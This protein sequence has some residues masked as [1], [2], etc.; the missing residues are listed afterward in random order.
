MDSGDIAFD[1]NRTDHIASGGYPKNATP[2][3]GAGIDRLLHRDRIQGNT[4]SNRPMIPYVE[5]S[6]MRYAD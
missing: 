2:G 1:L 6:S 5:I 4:V 3:F